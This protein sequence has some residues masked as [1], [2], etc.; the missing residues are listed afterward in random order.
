MV[1]RT[2]SKQ[3]SH[4]ISTSTFT[5]KGYGGSTSN[6]DLGAPTFN[7]VSSK[8]MTDSTNPGYYKA[9]REGTLLPVSPMTS[10]T[11]RYEFFPASLY[12]KNHFAGSPT[13]GDIHSGSGALFTQQHWQ[14]CL[15]LVTNLPSPPESKQGLLQ[16][17]LANA[18][19]DAWD[20][21]TF[22]A[23]LG[24]TV[25]GLVTLHSRWSAL[26][27]GV[28]NKALSR[29]RRF[30]NLAD[31][32][33][34]VWLEAR[35]AFRPLYYDM[36]SI[37]ESVK[38]LQEGIENP[39]CR[40]WATS[41]E[42]QAT[43]TFTVAASSAVNLAKCSVTNSLTNHASTGGTPGS[44]VSGFRERTVVNRATV[45][46]QVT[47][48]TVTMTDP[49]VT[50]LELVPFSWILEWFIS[51]GDTIRA[52]S[53]A[54][55]GSFRYATYTTTETDRFQIDF[56]PIRPTSTTTTLVWNALGGSYIEEIVKVTRTVEQ[57]TPTLDFRFDVDTAKIADLVALAWT[58]KLKYLKLLR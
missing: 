49:F 22:M 6:T 15:N 28:L 55:S 37:E 48:R 16:T 56:L 20:T 52:F 33:A 1:S 21:L 25:E 17:A 26:A 30:R 38:R 42:A 36:K 35:Y 4:V 50:A 12:W 13:K 9:K 3:L 45:G 7:C 57:V 41:A 14:T 2:R 10:T 43:S 24:K 19:T 31:A 54:A 18:Q 27:D 11:T 53:P 51:I 34:S 46:V 23:E 40:G 44:F 58:R 8:T 39:L 5:R 47:S 32:V 29:K